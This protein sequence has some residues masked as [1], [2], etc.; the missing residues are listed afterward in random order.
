MNASP[1]PPGGS[2]VAMDSP[3]AAFVPA[4]TG[5]PAKIIGVPPAPDMAALLTFKQGAEFLA[6]SA[7]TLWTLVNSGQLP[8]VRIGRLIRFR[9]EALV[10]W[11]LDNERGRK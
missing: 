10:D 4:D 1:N 11:T 2:P 3:G 5:K 8:H 7:R 6:V 9:R